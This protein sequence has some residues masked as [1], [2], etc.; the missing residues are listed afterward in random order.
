MRIVEDTAL[1]SERYQELYP[2]Q[3]E[4]IRSS[5][6]Y[7]ALDDDNGILG[8]L[9]V[10]CN[11]TGFFKRRDERFWRELLETFAVRLALQKSRLDLVG[12]D[13]ARQELGERWNPP[14]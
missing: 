1:P 9:V 12:S 6:V 4:R 3:K 10:H 8:T 5:V 11:R 14:F 7:P 13:T 2:G